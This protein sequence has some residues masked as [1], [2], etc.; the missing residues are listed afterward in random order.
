MYDDMRDMY[1][2][3][4]DLNDDMTDIND[5]MD[6]YVWI[7]MTCMISRSLGWE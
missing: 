7:T 5:D 1:D 6:R 3:M 2:D 4:T